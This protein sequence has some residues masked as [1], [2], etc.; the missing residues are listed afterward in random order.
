M[1][2][3]KVGD[4]SFTV[5]RVTHYGTFMSDI[6]NKTIVLV[7]NRNWQAI[8]IRTPQ[9]A[10]CMLATNVATVRW[11]GLTLRVLIR[12]ACLRVCCRTC[13]AATSKPW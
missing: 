3:L 8:N 12:A 11:G 9:V 6:L 4:A 1:R 10:F 7:L 13:S 2:E 5:S